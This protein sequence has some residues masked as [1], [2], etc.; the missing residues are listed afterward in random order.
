MKPRRYL[1][2]QDHSTEYP[3]PLSVAKGTELIVGERFA[4]PENWP[5]WVLCRVAGGEVEGW[6]PVQFI[7]MTGAGR[8]TAVEDYTA[9]ELEVKVG[10]VLLGFRELNG[11]VWCESSRD[12]NS[13]W[14]PRENLLELP[15]FTH[16]PL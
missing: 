12:S 6:V 3:V 11:W 16:D 2:T 4:G 14:V 8:G 15:P 9:R 13:G 10:E 7:Q 5:N 1:V